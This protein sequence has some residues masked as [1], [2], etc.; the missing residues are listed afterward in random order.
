MT[1]AQCHKNSMLHIHL[2]A[3]PKKKHRITE[4]IMSTIL[5]QTSYNLY[6]KI[7]QN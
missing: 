7:I 4:K 1:K 5:N 3:A 6:Y 2:H